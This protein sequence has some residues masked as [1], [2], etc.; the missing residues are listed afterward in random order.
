MA[1]SNSSEGMEKTE[2]RELVMQEIMKE[3]V[4]Y[5]ALEAR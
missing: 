2:D 1:A 3:W 5:S 4:V